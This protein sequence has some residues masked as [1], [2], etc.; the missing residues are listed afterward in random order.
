[1]K[2]TKELKMS[3]PFQNDNDFNRRYRRGDDTT[4]WAGILVAALVLMGAVLFF[5][6][7]RT[8]TTATN[9]PGT[10]TNQPASPSGTT[11]SAPAR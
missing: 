2:G 3:D 11:G 4:M 7:D 6:R 10:T 1:M 5:A 8:D 9:A